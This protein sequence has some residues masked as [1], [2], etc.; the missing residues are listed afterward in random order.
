MASVTSTVMTI[1]GTPTIFVPLPT[2][3]PSE[4]GC[5]TNIYQLA[6]TTPTFLAWDPAYGK[7]VTD[8]ASCIPSQVSTWRFQDPDALLYTAIGPTFVCPEAYSTVS[9]TVTASSVQ[10]VY[11][12]PSQYTLLS[13][14]PNEAAV[15]PS[16]WTS[17]ITE[18]QTLS[19]FTGMA[20][21]SSLSTTTVFTS[22]AT[23][24]AGPVNGFNIAT[25]SQATATDSAAGG[26]QQTT[27]PSSQSPQ[28]S[29][30]STG[31]STLGLSI[32]ITLGIVFAVLLLGIAAFVLW[33][34][35]RA[36]LARAHSKGSDFGASPDKTELDYEGFAP[37]I[38]PT[39]HSNTL[40]ELPVT[41]WNR[42]R[43]TN[44]QE[45]GK[46]DL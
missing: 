10:K 12:C 36:R 3:Y 35:R 24:F 25:S 26:T 14:H 23:M 15:F 18:G 2:P 33:R 46:D 6:S 5:G 38:S 1:G 13:A 42:D 44:Y 37:V 29:A 45:G 34:R 39:Q 41:K 19:W 27:T 32:G 16:Q 30:S 11:C 40:E 43:F 22:P 8:A 7:S 28:S 9:T 4:D 20:S 31:T 21:G 17:M